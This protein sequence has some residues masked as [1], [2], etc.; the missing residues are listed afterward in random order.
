MWISC[1][2]YWMGCATEWRRY[3][4]LTIIDHFQFT[5]KGSGQNLTKRIE[6]VKVKGWLHNIWRRHGMETLS[7]YD[8]VTGLLCGEFTGHRW[9]PRTKTS[10]AEL[11]CF[12]W[13]APE[14]K[15]EQI[16]ETPVF[17]RRHSAHNDVIAMHCR[18]AVRW[19]HRWPLGNLHIGSVMW[20][21]DVSLK[22]V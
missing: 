13:S 3:H 9:I 12:L 18:A 22:L 20:S 1:D 10:D 15:V 4:G 14:P 11:W 21:F 17:L 16:M 8:D 19:N 2:Q 6:Q 7:V 5:S